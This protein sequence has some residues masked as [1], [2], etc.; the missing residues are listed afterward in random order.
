MP[1]LLTDISRLAFAVKL[2]ISFIHTLSSV[3]AVNLHTRVHPFAVGPKVPHI[4]HT[5]ILVRTD[6]FAY[7]ILPTRVALTWSYVVTL[8]L[9]IHFATVWTDTMVSVGGGVA[10]GVL[11]AWVKHARVV[12]FA[13]VPVV[14][15]ETDT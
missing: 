5:S 11:T 6:I 13:S 7:P 8:F 14:A 10:T 3:V 1:S 2:D 9:V 12:I 15:Q 4:T